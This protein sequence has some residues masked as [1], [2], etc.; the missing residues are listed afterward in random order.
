MLDASPICVEGVLLTQAQTKFEVKKAGT[1]VT[2][3]V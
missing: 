1:E 2:D 3:N